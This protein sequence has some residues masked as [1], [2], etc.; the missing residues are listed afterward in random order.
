MPNPV[1]RRRRPLGLGP[2]SAGRCADHTARQPGLGVPPV[3]PMD[4]RNYPPARPAP[5]VLLP[6]PIPGTGSSRSA[7]PGF[8]GGPVN[9][10][11]GPRIAPRGSDAPGGLSGYTRVKEGLASGRKP[12]LDGFDVLKQAGFRTVLYL[13]AAG[14]DWSAAKEVATKRG[15]AFVALETTPEKLSSAIEQFNATVADTARHPIYVCDDDGVAWGDLVSS[16]PHRRFAQRRRGSR[17]C[18]SA[19]TDGRGDEA[20]AFAIAARYSG[21][22]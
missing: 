15:L 8:L 4:L 14:A 12:S 9:P 22:R 13:H 10:S 1:A 20:R 17:S 2:A 6:D 5:E 3:G 11:A 21:N 18:P 16:F 7:L 19:R